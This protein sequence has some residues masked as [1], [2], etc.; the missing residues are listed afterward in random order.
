MGFEA[1]HSAQK[2][3]LDD[4]QRMNEIAVNV[5]NSKRG[6]FLKAMADTWLRADPF[7]K[8]ILRQA[9]QAFIVKYSLDEEAE[10]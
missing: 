5:Y 3:Y 6:S 2:I 8:R 10:G 9:W 7:N 1:Y 4:L